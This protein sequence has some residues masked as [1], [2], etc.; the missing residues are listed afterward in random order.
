MRPNTQPLHSITF[1]SRNFT[2]LLIGLLLVLSTM[3]V[4][5]APTV[6][7]AASAKQAA[8]TNI[9]LSTLTMTNRQRGWAL[10]QNETHVFSTREG[11]EHW[12]DVTPKSLNLPENDFLNSITT[13]FFLD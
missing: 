13:S 3:L 1:R 4:I 11:P 8:G 7:K 2:F 6:V 5:S 12:S 9:Q 10:D